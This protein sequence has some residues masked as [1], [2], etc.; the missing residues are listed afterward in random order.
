MQ[1]LSTG[2]LPEDWLKANISPIFKKGNRNL[3]ENYRPVSLTCICCKIFE[4]IICK[5]IR[6]HLDKY[7]ILSIFQHGFRYLHSCETQL[8]L[9]LHDL[10]FERDNNTQIDLAILDFSKAF[11]TVPHNHLLSKL[12]HYGINGSIHTWIS[13]FLK[14]RTQ[15]VVVDGVKSESVT[16]DSGVPQGT[17]LGPLLFLLH[18]NDLPQSVTSTVRLF[19]DDCLLYRPI[20]S[21]ADQISLQT[22]LD[23]LHSWGITWGMRFNAKK[24]NIMT[25]SRSKSPLTKFYH[26]SGQVL[27]EVN[28]A[29]YL[30]VNISQDLSWTSHIASV[31][32]RGNYSLAFLRRNL[33]GCP[34][35]LKQ[36]GYN[37]LVRSLLEYSAP[38]WDPHYAKDIQKIEKVQRRA[39]RFVTN[40]YDW[41]C[42][43]TGM[44]KKLGWK[45][46]KDRRRELRLSLLYKIV[47]E[48]VAIQSD[49]LLTKA[50]ARTRSSHQHK[51]RQYTC[52]TNSFKSSFIPRTIPEWN[53]LPAGVIE[54]PNTGAFKAAVSK[55][56]D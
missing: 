9:T 29:K 25:I 48:K 53:A 5:H 54:A 45:T 43:V 55:H 7:N 35:E 40:N 47:N 12:R 20:H 52:N 10:L 46:L 51:Y 19:A 24:C 41:S 2:E 30:G 32:Q 34:A 1:T 50:D 21:T 23:R 16:V 56:Y 27:E 11:D 13:T 8:L 17:V 6:N 22:D 15:C 33:K 3:P 49:T 31:A 44:M 14:C 26:L 28:M 4:H 36:L 39:A 42:S 38:I 18:I 37:S